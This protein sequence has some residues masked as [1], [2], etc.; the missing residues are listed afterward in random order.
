VKQK[1]LKKINFI[2][3]DIEGAERD[4]LRGAKETLRTMHPKLAICEY[5]LPDDPEVLEAIIKEANPNYVIEHK[6]MKLYAYVPEEKQNN[7]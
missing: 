2:K 4:M 3:A 5:H 6:Y 1:N 7:E